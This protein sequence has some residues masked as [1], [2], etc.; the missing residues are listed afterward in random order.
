MMIS[1]VVTGNQVV[2]RM[3]CNRVWLCTNNSSA[4]FFSLPCVMYF[5]GSHRPREKTTKVGGCVH[6][7]KAFDLC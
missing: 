4:T 1:C 5:S 7:K 2:D 3:C 6:V